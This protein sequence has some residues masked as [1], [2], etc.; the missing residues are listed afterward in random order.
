M[1]LHPL[2]ALMAAGALAPA[3]AS[4]AGFP[5]PGMDTTKSGATAPGDPYRYV[6]YPGGRYA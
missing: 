2:V 5:A 1:R 3:T 6:A 4:A